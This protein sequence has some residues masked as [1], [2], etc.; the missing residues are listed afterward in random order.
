MAIRTLC[1]NCGG[2]NVAAH[3][4]HFNPV[5]HIT[6]HWERSPSENPLPDGTPHPDP[7][8]EGD[9]AACNAVFILCN[10]CGNIQPL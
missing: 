5:K 9:S 6:H 8:P 2:D 7:C 1:Q 3:Y 10:E 4:Q